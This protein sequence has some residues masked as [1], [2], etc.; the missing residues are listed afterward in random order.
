MRGALLLSL[1]ILFSVV[2]SPSV[3]A[4]ET[5]SSGRAR[6]VTVAMDSHDAYQVVISGNKTASIE[7]TADS[8]VDFYVMTAS[9]YAEYTDPNSSVFHT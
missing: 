9:G 2:L 6:T 4:L 8:I 5:I 7:F 3:T 1:S